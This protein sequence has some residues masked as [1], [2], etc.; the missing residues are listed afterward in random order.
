MFVA[1]AQVVPA[2]LNERGWRGAAWPAQADFANKHL[3]TTGT[4][5]RVDDCWKSFISTPP[6]K[7]LQG[8]YGVKNSIPYQWTWFPY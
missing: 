4:P 1:H 6:R 3:T 5:T 2:S 7:R 8:N